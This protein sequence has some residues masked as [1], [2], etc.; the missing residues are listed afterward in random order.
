[1]KSIAAAFV[2]AVMLFA[3]AAFAACPDITGPYC[4]FA[5]CWYQYEQAP[6][7]AGTT[8]NVS[9]TTLWCYN[10]PAKSFGTGSSSATYTFTVGANDPVSS[11][12]DVDL[13]YVEWSDPNASIYN[14]LTATVSVTHNGSTSSQTFYS[15][16]GT[17]TKSCA[18]SNYTTFYA[19]AGDTVSVTINTTIYNSNVTAKVGAPLIFANQ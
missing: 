10:T 5:G 11:S 8:G 4:M 7:C 19:T 9:N 14:T 6:T 15:I 3:P 16:N 13:R 12:Y 1:M 17:V 18:L 2:V